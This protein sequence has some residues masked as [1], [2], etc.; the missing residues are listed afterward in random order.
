MRFEER[1]TAYANTVSMI[2]LWGL[3]GLEVEMGW[4]GIRLH[5]AVM[6]GQVH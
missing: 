4:D 1:G 3:D 6:L 5:R 2:T